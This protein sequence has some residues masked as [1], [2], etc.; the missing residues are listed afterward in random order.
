MQRAFING[1]DEIA[2]NEARSTGRA[3]RVDVMDIPVSEKLDSE[4]RRILRD[5]SA[6]PDPDEHRAQREK[7][8]KRSA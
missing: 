1:H 2:D 4:V 5:E 8:K 3:L 6:R 7:Q